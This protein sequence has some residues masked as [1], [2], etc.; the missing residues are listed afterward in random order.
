MTAG[1]QRLFRHATRS[2]GC[3]PRWGTS[4]SSSWLMASKRPS[5]RSRTAG[6]GRPSSLPRDER[7]AGPD[8]RVDRRHPEAE[9]L[10]RTSPAG[11]SPV[12]DRAGRPGAGCRC[13]TGPHPVSRRRPGETPAAWDEEE[14]YPAS[15][16]VE[17]ILA[18]DTPCSRPARRSSSRSSSGMA[19]ALEQ[20][21]FEEL[22][23]R[24]STGGFSR[25]SRRRAGESDRA[26]SGKNPRGPVGDGAR[27]SRRSSG[28][29]RRRTSSLPLPTSEPGP[30]ATSSTLRV[31]T[32]ALDR[33]LETVGELI[34]HRNWLGG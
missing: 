19:R 22:A 32:E 13:G 21:R 11:S 28:P 20:P 16:R 7:R 17:V 29:A 18:S 2:K 30:V 12:L 33:F 1:H 34:V 25:S 31:R 26:R 15:L 3:P 5:S 6:W 9:P 14:A 8:L 23:A 24:I 27:A 10:P 4:P